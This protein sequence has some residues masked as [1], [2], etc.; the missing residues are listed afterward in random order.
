MERYDLEKLRA[1]P[2]A[3]VA[4]RLRLKVERHRALCPFH[5]DHH[6]SM[7][8]DERHNVY[9]CWSCGAHGDGI[10]L[11]MR[12]LKMG[13]ADACRWLADGC[14]MPMTQALLQRAESGVEADKARTKFDA[15]R[16]QRYFERPWLSDAARRF[17]YEE[18]HLH[19]A[20]V[21]FCHLNS[22]GDWLQIPYYDQEGGLVG[23]QQR[24]MGNDTK[25]PRFKFGT[26]ERTRLYNQQILGMLQEGE[27]LYLGEGP[28]DVW[29]LLSA[30]HKA[31][32]IPSATLLKTSDLKVLEGLLPRH[33]TLHISTM[34]KLANV[35]TKSY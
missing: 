26:G 22:F 18:R 31:I 25:Q 27:P 8:I 10:D 29:A 14:C 15:S 12:L 28:S 9:R 7:S 1:I 4:R 30:G 17:L 6:P 19:P 35:S 16:Y 3:D 11:V 21:G 20:V 32:G 5:D 23:V 13:F 2:I 24:Y 34:T 33:T